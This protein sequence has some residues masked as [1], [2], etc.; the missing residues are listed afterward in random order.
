[1]KTFSFKILYISIFAPSILYV[2]TLPYVEL[3]LQ[4]DVTRTVRQQLVREDFNLLQGKVSLY[5]EVNKNVTAVLERS[6]AARLGAEVRVRITDAYDNV[7][8]P[9]Y[10]H[11]LFS[12]RHEASPEKT[13]GPLFDE[14]GFA[15]EP[16]AQGLEELLQKYSEY[17]Q[18]MQIL[19]FVKVPVTSWLG[20]GILL[21]FI[22][23]TVILV[24]M[25]YQR[26]STLE[27]IKLHEIEVRHEEEKQVLTE[28]VESE[29]QAARRR[30]ADI[31]SQE[32][33]WLQEVERLEKEKARLEDELLE[34]LERSEEQK[35]KIGK[36]EDKVVKKSGKSR[37]VKEEQALHERFARLY[38]NLEIDRKAVG[39]L[40]RLK[41]GTLKLQAEEVLKRLNDEDPSLK[42]RRK[43]AGVEKCDA[44]ELTFGSS[45]RIYYIASDVR[46]FR[47][48]RI[49]TKATQRKDLASLQKTSK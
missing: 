45:G 22:L 4:H 5:D 1:M 32:E 10:D 28:R 17:L 18:G 30:L 34:T 11:L 41:E 31:Q 7:I 15:R 36:L 49:G 25:Y 13:P 20:S 37:T 29:L 14:K 35:E 3:W 21:L 26:S 38:R 42:V 12:F 27:E 19:V 39:D 48:L 6:R 2:L 33:E 23:T 46:R 8:Y 9:Y 44:Y 47:V 43:I 40:V 16:A 24:Y